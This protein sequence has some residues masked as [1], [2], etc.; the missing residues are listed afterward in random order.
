MN[1]WKKVYPLIGALL[2]L[3]FF[4]VELNPG[5]SSYSFELNILDCDNIQYMSGC[6]HEIGHKMD[7]DLGSPSL[8]SEFGNAVQLYIMVG[9]MHTPQDK[10]A[11]T[12][13]TYPGVFQYDKT[14]PLM[15]QREVYAAIYAWVDGDVSKLPDSFKPF[16]SDDPSYL[17]LYDCLAKN[18][19]NICGQSIS[20]LKRET[21]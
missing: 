19:L 11:V 17:D 21:Q 10:L 20:S 14:H 5:T 12:L 6:R 9:L 13:L 2:V 8:T 4:V 18:G 16:Y 7:D 15:I 1:A 3:A